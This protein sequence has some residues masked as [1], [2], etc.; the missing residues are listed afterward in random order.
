[1]GIDYVKKLRAVDYRKNR[2]NDYNIF[3]AKVQKCYNPVKRFVDKEIEKGLNAQNAID[4]V[5]ESTSIAMF[6]NELNEEAVKRKIKSLLI[7]H[8]S[9]RDKTKQGDER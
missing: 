5:L 2:E 7:N 4:K 9:N 6:C 8:Y 3:V 1:M